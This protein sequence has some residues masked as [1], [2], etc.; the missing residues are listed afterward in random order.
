MSLR[1]VS[2]RQLEVRSAPVGPAPPMNVA[3]DVPGPPPS[4][5]GF[6]T[7]FSHHRGGRK[8]V[9][10]EGR[11]GEGTDNRQGLL[12]DHPRPAGTTCENTKTLADAKPR[13]SE[14]YRQFFQGR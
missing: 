12:S 6:V 11:E 8:E 9:E 13:E 4:A 14:Q 10:V 7:L 2:W 3:M 5:V 1:F